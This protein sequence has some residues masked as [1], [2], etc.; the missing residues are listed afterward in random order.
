MTF[1][2]KVR[3]Y[4]I[5]GGPCDIYFRDFIRSLHN[6][7]PNNDTY[8]VSFNTTRSP[9]GNI[10]TNQDSYSTLIPPLFLRCFLFIPTRTFITTITIITLMLFIINNRWM[11]TTNKTRNIQQRTQQHIPQHLNQHKRQRQHQYTCYIDHYIIHGNFLFWLLWFGL[12][13][14]YESYVKGG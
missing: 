10:L 4:V 3:G 14:S 1:H 9:I 8:N 13:K 11:G 7:N 5:T 12:E 6:V 2:N